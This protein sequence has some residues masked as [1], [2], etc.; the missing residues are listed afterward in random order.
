MGELPEIAEIPA[1]SGAADLSAR[2]VYFPVRHH[3]PACAWHVGRLIREL[4]PEA[5]LI[6][7]PRDASPLIPLLLHAETRMPAA[8][9]ATYVERRAKQLPERHA[10]YYP[11]CDFS[12]ELAALRAAAEVGAGASFID[13]TFAEM[14]HAR[15]EAPPQ[16]AESLQNERLLTHG[17]LLRIACRQAS[18]P[19]RRRSVGSTLRGRLPASRYVAV[20]AQRADLLWAGSAEL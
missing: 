15:R 13:L 4:R 6:E 1:L 11:L 16:R 10:A 5:V 8:I 12:P 7:G 20:H 18:R 17:E 9:Y 3:S 14:V 19:R 2:V